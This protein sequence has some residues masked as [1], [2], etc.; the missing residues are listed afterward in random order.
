MDLYEWQPLEEGAFN[1]DEGDVSLNLS[2]HSSHFGSSDG[3]ASWDNDA[4]RGRE[5]EEKEE[6][7]RLLQTRHRVERLLERLERYSAKHVSV[8]GLARLRR[9]MERELELLNA[10]VH[11]AS[12]QNDGAE[13]HRPHSQGMN[14]HHLETVMLAL[15]CEPGVVSVCTSVRSTGGSG[16]S[17][18]QGNVEVDVVSCDGL[19]WVKVRAASTRRL[20]AEMD[21][22]GWEAALSR[23][24][25]RARARRL[26]F[27]R[28][29]EVV[30]LFRDHPPPAMVDGILRL[31]A[32]PVSCAALLARVG[33]SGAALHW[34][35][36]DFLPPL[37]F[38]V[39]FV[40]FDTTALVALCSEAC[41]AD[42]IEANVVALRNF[43]VMAEQHRRELED[44]CVRRHVEP[45]LQR[46][47]AWLDTH[48]FAAAMS[49]SMQRC[50]G[51]STCTPTANAIE[52]A[53]LEEL[54]AATTPA[55]EMLSPIRESTVVRDVHD[56]R[57]ERLL[58]GAVDSQPN[59]IVADITLAEFRW[60]LETIAG[61][62]ELRRALTL[63]RCCCAVSM[64]RRWLD[65]GD[66]PLLTHVSVLAAKESISLRNRLVFG[67]GD[68]VG[69][70]VLSS[71]RQIL[72]A[73][74]DEGVEL[75]VVSHPA[76]ALMEQKINSMPRRDGPKTPPPIGT[77]G[78]DGT[79]Q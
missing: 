79:Q 17:A 75:L 77:S 35:G 66:V 27:M 49:E 3:L 62:R 13:L 38:A 57:C 54:V 34:R 51:D 20:L 32:R 64:D 44:P 63:L 76:R 24:L 18:A 53:W 21:E 14:A 4:E 7:T 55:D 16:D 40:C 15:E 68:A 28:R 60:I 45:A 48:R 26:P 70:V 2:A 8:K 36:T 52:L 47:T 30:V 31:G 71:N 6:V 9:R 11:T 5:E 25:A 74:R 39:N 72:H 50:G 1:G 65:G 69:A 23:L 46:Y 22:P 12:R 41:F 67:L 33:R 56:M 10:A 29:P 61:P 42:S 19:R 37:S 73:A 59:W 78:G 58:R 43:R